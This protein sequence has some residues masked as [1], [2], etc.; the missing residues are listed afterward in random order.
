MR[1]GVWPGSLISQ[2]KLLD[3]GVTVA[4]PSLRMKVSVKTSNI[5]MS[6]T[7]CTDDFTA[8]CCHGRWQRSSE[9]GKRGSIYFTCGLAANF[10]TGAPLELGLNHV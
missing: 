8:S 3:R 7:P 6:L 5:I 10:M 1:L 2:P 9:I 4:S